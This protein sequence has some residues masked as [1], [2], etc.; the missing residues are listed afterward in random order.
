MTYSKHPLMQAQMEKVAFGFK[1]MKSIAYSAPVMTAGAMIALETGSGLLSSGVGKLKNMYERNSSY[2]GMMEMSPELRSKDQKTVKRYFNSLHR[3]NPHFMNDPLIAGGIVQQAVEAQESMGGLKAPA[4]AV[5]RMA[6]DLVK[7]R[8][9]FAAAIQREAPTGPS[10]A[11]Q[12]RP[13]LQAGI[14]QAHAMRLGDTPEGR[15]KAQIDK[16]I[17]RLEGLE[18]NQLK[19]RRQ[20]EVEAFNALRSQQDQQ[21]G[22]ARARISAAEASAAGLENTPPRGGGAFVS[23]RRGGGAA[24]V[25]TPGRSYVSPPDHPYPG[26]VGRQPY[27]P[28]ASTAEQDAERL[29]RGT[30]AFSRR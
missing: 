1:D 20:G 17:Q 5:S 11:Q 3:L 14:E 8:S 12:L 13:V 19:V 6:G 10:I 25:V 21:L 9:D 28:P 23:A 15:L 24:R 16:D 26:G 29:M 27:A 30:R 22:A 18:H 2:K 7:N 4:M